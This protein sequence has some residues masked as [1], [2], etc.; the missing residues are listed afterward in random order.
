MKIKCSRAWSFGIQRLKALD[1]DHN[2]AWKLGWINKEVFTS[3]PAEFWFQQINPTL[4]WE[5]K[6]T[7]DQAKQR[8]PMMFITDR[9]MDPQCYVRDQYLDRYRYKSSEK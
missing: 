2:S 3:Q 5:Q 9:M 6:L 8:W 1:S 4:N 7:G